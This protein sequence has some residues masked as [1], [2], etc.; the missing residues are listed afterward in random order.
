LFEHKKVV[1]GEFDACNPVVLES[2]QLKPFAHGENQEQKNT[3]AKE[4]SQTY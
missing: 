4:F 3:N 2:G 1:G